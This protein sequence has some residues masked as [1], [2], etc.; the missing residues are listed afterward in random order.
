MIF[1]VNLRECSGAENHD[2]PNGMFLSKDTTT[3][4]A[5]FSC[6]PGYEFSVGAPAKVIDCT[7]CN[8][9]EK[10]WSSFVGSCTGRKNAHEE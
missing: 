6:L 8:F 1:S 4:E 2:P 7:D 9:F 10:P 5:T 3:G